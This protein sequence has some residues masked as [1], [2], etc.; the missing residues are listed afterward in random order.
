MKNCSPLTLLIAL[1]ALN[2]YAADFDR[3]GSFDFPTSASPQAQEHFLLG[4]GYLHS[5]GNTQAQAEFRRAQELDPDFALAFWGEVFTYQHPFFGAK[6]DRPGEVMMRLGASSE[7]RL[8][9]AACV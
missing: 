4:V 5:F 1:F 2:A 7:E 8:A 9:K 6:D 3:I